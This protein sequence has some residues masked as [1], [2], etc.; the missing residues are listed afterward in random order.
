M[1]A[2]S[3]GLT[4]NKFVNVD[5]KYSRKVRSMVHHLF[6]QGE[7][8]LVDKKSREKRNGKINELAGMLGFIDSLDKYNNSLP[9]DRKITL[10]KRE[11]LYG[12]FLYYIAF[13]ANAIPVILTE[14]KTDITY[15]RVALSALAAKYPSL[16]GDKNLANKAVHDYKIKY[17]QKYSQK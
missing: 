4:V 15:L 2:R 14:G 9:H 17:F 6:I 11:R 5:A 12:E 13:W 10:N 7:Y 16:I 3:Y 8:Q 1:P